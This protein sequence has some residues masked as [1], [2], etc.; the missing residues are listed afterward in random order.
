MKMDK[1]KSKGLRIEQK[2]RK[3]LSTQF[4]TQF[5]KKRLIIG[6]K[7][8]G[9][10]IYHEFDLVSDDRSIVGE[11]KSYKFGNRRTGKSGYTTTRKAR[12]IM[13]CFYLEKIPANTKLL[14]LTNKKLCDEF[15]YD[16]NGLLGSNIIIMYIPIK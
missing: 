12:L 7:S 2:V 4:N 8:N 13:A 6:H 16:L 11:V 15:K 10:D 1:L 14:V 9:K 3:Y 5:K